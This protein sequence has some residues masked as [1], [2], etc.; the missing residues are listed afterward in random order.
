MKNTFIT[1]KAGLDAQEVD[2]QAFKDAKNNVS[3]E[4]WDITVKWDNVRKREDAEEWFYTVCP[5]GI[6]THT[7]KESEP[8]WYP[9]VEEV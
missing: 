3:H 1:E 2:F 9:E 8:S 5:V 4:Y 7:Q 6:Q